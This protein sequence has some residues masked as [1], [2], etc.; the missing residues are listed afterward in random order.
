MKKRDI[1][2]TVGSIAGNL[3]R[4][5]LPLLLGN[6]FQQLYNMV[7]TWVIGQSGN[8]GAYAAVGSV[9]PVINTLI[10]FFSGLATGSGVV[11]SQYFGAK[12]EKKV[13][14]AV[15][16]AM[17]LTVVFAVVFSVLGYFL[18]PQL[19]SL[20]LETDNSDPAVL[21]A[22]SVYL[23]IYFAGVSGLM[24]YNMGS[25]ILRAVGDSDRPFYFLVVSTVT[26]IILDLLFVNRLGM[27][28]DGV[29]LATVISQFISA[30]LVM[31]VLLTTDSVVRVTVRDVRFD[32]VLLKAIVIIGIPTALQLSITAFS[33]VFVQSYIAGANGEQAILLGGWT[34]Y[35]KVD[36]FIFLPITSLGLAVSTFVGQCLGKNDTKRAKKGTYIAYA[37]ATG[38]TLVVLL[39]VELF[40]PQISS[41]F[42]RDENVVATA[43]MLLRR[44]TPFYLFCCVN[45]VFLGALRGSGDS[46]AAMV[47]TLSSFVALRQVYLFVMSHYISN[48]LL[49]IGFGYPVGWMLCCIGVLI[50][51]FTADFGARS[52]VKRNPEKQS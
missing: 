31:R 12:D 42:N 51:F 19:A 44:L 7:D 30:I 17:M 6:L 3:I 28:A 33:N 46:A 16:T 8:N 24:F 18:A 13:H 15:H 22:A 27:G 50:Y 40:A 29:A 1:D 14:R 4:F 32:P 21:E 38:I 37:M 43:A 52:L 41:V 35:S 10:G 34:T 49:P 2:M 20:M 11:I 26:N 36:Q 9:G 25:G 48:E 5:T 23:R 39:I 47:I 45:Q